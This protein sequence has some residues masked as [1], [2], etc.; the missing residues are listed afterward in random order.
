LAFDTLRAM[1]PGALLVQGEMHF[2]STSV[3]WHLLNA[4]RS[5]PCTKSAFWS[6]LA[7]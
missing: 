5:L 1:R 3:S 6:R 7:D 4:M 2:S